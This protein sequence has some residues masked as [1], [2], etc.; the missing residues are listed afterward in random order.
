[1]PIFCCMK[2]VQIWIWVIFEGFGLLR[3]R[4][5]FGRNIRHAKRDW[6]TK[7]FWLIKHLTILKILVLNYFKTRTNR[8]K[9]FGPSF[10]D[11]LNWKQIINHGKPLEGKKS[12]VLSQ[13]VSYLSEMG[14]N[15][16]QGLKFSARQC[17]WLPIK[18]SNMVGNSRN[19]FRPREKIWNFSENSIL[20]KKRSKIF[21]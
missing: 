21:Y 9:S 19:P 1:M 14:K 2:I 3:A 11:H 20:Q 13:L 15:L 12:D 18:P 6:R 8:E 10:W 4:R 16:F 7:L 5:K 17:C